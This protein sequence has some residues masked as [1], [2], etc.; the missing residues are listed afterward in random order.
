MSVNLFVAVTDDDWFDYLRNLGPIDEINFWQPGGRTAFRALKAGELFL[1]KLHSPNDFVVGGGIFAHASIL[2]V[3]LAWEAFQQKNGAPT[4]ETMRA[5]ISRYRRE[6]VRPHE[7][8]QIG[9][10]IL[11]SPFFLPREQWI[12][13]PSNWSRNIVVGKTFNTDDSEGNQLWNA[14]QERRQFAELLP[15]DET[16]PRYGNPVLIRPR[17]GQGTFRIAV[18][19][20]YHRRCAVSGERTLPVLEAAHIRPYAQGGLHEVSNG[21]LLRSDLHR[22]FDLGYVTVTPDGVFEVSPRIKA[23]FE[24][25]RQYYALHGNRV[26]Q[27][28]SLELRPSPQAVRWHNEHRFRS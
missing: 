9:C 21:L 20:V 27:P 10:R 6:P 15:R 2:P 13:I 3:S 17:L 5:R 8:Y 12:P 25:G 18:A 19:D 11:E 23:E 24:N 14:L 16:G 7:D 28:S 4:L 1:F 22:L 26:S